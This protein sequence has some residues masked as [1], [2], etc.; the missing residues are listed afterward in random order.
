VSAAT[1]QFKPEGVRFR[2]GETKPVELQIRLPDDLQTNSVYRGMIKLRNASLVL[3]VK[4]IVG[5]KASPRR[6]R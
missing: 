1:V 6:R 2:A 3:E 5:S 4:C